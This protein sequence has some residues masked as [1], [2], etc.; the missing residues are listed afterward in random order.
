MFLTQ[1]TDQDVEE[2]T[3]LISQ[4]AEENPDAFQTALAVAGGMLGAIIVASIVFYILMVIAWWKIFTKAGEKG[5]KSLIPIYNAYIQYKITWSGKMFWIML[6]IAIV[7]G[8]FGSLMGQNPDNTVYSIIYIVILL[9][10]FVLC[11]M[12]VHY[13]SKSYGHGVLFTIGLIFLPNIF[14]LILGFGSSEYI[15]PKGIPQGAAQTE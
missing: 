12:G 7:M 4:A 5:W 6:G 8:V 14:T 15:G 3:N 13:L 10:F 11:I 2:L 1:T 9:V